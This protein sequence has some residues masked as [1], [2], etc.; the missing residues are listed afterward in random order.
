MLYVPEDNPNSEICREGQTLGHSP[1][2]FC[3]WPKGTLPELGDWVPLDPHGKQRPGVLAIDLYNTE[4]VA[5]LRCRYTKGYSGNRIFWAEMRG[6]QTVQCLVPKPEGWVPASDD[7][8]FEKDSKSF[9]SGISTRS[10][11]R[12]GTY[13]ANPVR[14]G[15]EEIGYLCP[16]IDDFDVDEDHLPF[17]PWCFG[18]WIK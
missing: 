2:N 8:P 14:H 18:T 17:H 5:G 16:A 7:Q 13:F 10:N 12:V 4:H 6:C 3:D 11:T 15:I 9:L 1:G